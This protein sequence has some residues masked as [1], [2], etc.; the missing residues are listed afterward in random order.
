MLQSVTM[1]AGCPYASL[2]HFR[3][4]QSFYLFHSVDSVHQMSA[5][6]PFKRLKTSTRINSCEPC[7]SRK[8]R[9][10]RSLPCSSCLV[11]GVECTWD[12]AA[13]EQVIRRPM[14]TSSVE[15]ARHDVYAPSS[16]ST[17]QNTPVS[18]AMALLRQAEGLL[19]GATSAPPPAT[20]TGS[21]SSPVPVDNPDTAQE[22]NH[23]QPVPRS[24]R[25]RQAS[26]SADTSSSDESQEFVEPALRSGNTF[27]SLSP[28]AK[29]RFMRMYCKLLRMLPSRGRL[30]VILEIYFARLN[31][32]TYIFD[33]AD[34]QARLD[35]TY[36][37]LL[38]LR[39]HMDLNRMQDN[40][41][42]LP[43]S[44]REPTLEELRIVT[45][46]MLLTLRTQLQGFPMDQMR[47]DQ[48]SVASTTSPSPHALLRLCQR[49]FEYVDPLEKESTLDD[50]RL[51]LLFIGC[52]CIIKGTAKAVMYVVTSS[53]LGVKHGLH[54]EPRD[55]L[56][57]TKIRDH[58]NLFI[59]VCTFDWIGAA[60]IKSPSFMPCCPEKQPLLFQDHLANAQLS[61]GSGEPA[62]HSRIP[63]PLQ[64]L[65]LTPRMEFHFQCALVSQ[66]LNTRRWHSPSSLDFKFKTKGAQSALIHLAKLRDRCIA[67]S[68]LHGV[69]LVLAEG[70][71]DIVLA[72]LE[73]NAERSIEV[74]SQELNAK[75]PRSEQDQRDRTQRSY[76]HIIS[77]FARIIRDLTACQIGLDPHKR[78]ESSIT[79]NISTHG[80]SLEGDEDVDEYLDSIAMKV[81]FQRRPHGLRDLWFSTQVTARALQAHYLSRAMNTETGAQRESANLSRSP[82]QFQKDVMLVERAVALL[83]EQ[84]QGHLSAST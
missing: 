79:S 70:S 50:L 27:A 20:S 68:E 23:Q 47:A 41:N 71:M 66:L 32:N 26:F 39:D 29:R 55:S 53:L 40:C 12:E 34:L 38:D 81:I 69:D 28:R 49:A 42:G 35:D 8:T 7:R 58:L 2:P 14:R 51:C 76:G 13:L 36:P 9:C 3:R 43:E 10:D 56:P 30:T 16:A 33:Q 80:N 59:T 1:G 19:R 45:T 82:T 72:T 48:T 52:T 57:P 54:E 17:S 37:G 64:A 5:S 65:V 25:S 4:T 60:S 44:V 73:C 15:A 78:R 18:Q 6:R 74:L 61:C 63:I 11:R 83:A 31:E 62:P 67:T 21:G 46:V 84:R 24:S 22:V 77:V 75:S